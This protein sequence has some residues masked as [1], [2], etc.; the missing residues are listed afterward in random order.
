MLDHKVVVHTLDDIVGDGLHC[1][2]FLNRILFKWHRE[3]LLVKFMFLA[4]VSFVKFEV[5]V[6]L[7]A[8]QVLDI[9][10]QAE[11][12]FAVSLHVFLFC[13]QHLLQC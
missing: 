9:V 2:L 8:D 4:E 12:S 5:L 3:G 6:R 7:L 1:I 13:F 11:V 10:G